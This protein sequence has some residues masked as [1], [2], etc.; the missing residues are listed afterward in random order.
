MTEKKHMSTALRIVQSGRAY[1]PKVYCLWGNAP[2]SCRR[3]SSEQSKRGVSLK[4]GFFRGQHYRDSRSIRTTLQKNNHQYERR[5]SCRTQ[6]SVLLP[7][8]IQNIL[9]LAFSA[10]LAARDAHIRESWVQAMEA[11]I[12][13]DQLQ[14]C[15][16]AEGV[17]H[18][19]ACRELSEKYITM[20]KE[21]RVGSRFLP[22]KLLVVDQCII[23]VK[24]YKQVDV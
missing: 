17:N 21:N 10:R 1:Q 3:A 5:Q 24:G 12:V 13:R 9:I 8:L 7:L 22:W 18:Y 11:R 14:S 4:A 19:E 6:G 16:R 2:S 23:Q 15:Y 20:L